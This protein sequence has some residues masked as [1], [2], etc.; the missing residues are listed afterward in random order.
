MAA[1]LL[2]WNAHRAN[3]ARAG[4][5]PG[6]F[7]PVAICSPPATRHAPG[8]VPGRQKPSTSTGIW[9]SCYSSPRRL[10]V[11]AAV[12]GADERRRALATRRFGI[13]P[14]HATPPLRP[15]P[16]AP[17]LDVFMPTAPSWSSWKPAGLLS[18]PGP[19]AGQAGLPARPPSAPVSDALIIFGSTAD[20]RA[21]R[22][23]PGA[24]NTPPPGRQF[25][26][27]R[28]ENL[29]SPSSP[30]WSPSSPGAIDL[31]LICD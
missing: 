26:D 28:V 20:L 4:R 5:R 29:T 18:A 3:P 10:A 24:G 25:R 19:R 27:R 13:L 7:R 30:A 8:P 22:L 31:P 6:R 17:R 12:G 15:A 11:L 9:P 2:G 1:S 23:R 16:R 21:S 14:P